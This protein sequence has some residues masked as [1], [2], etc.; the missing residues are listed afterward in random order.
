M[1]TVGTHRHIKLFV[2]LKTPDKFPDLITMLLKSSIYNA[3]ALHCYLVFFILSKCR[4]E[5][6]DKRLSLI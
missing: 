4:S 5:N 1:T 2:I 6:S 3:L